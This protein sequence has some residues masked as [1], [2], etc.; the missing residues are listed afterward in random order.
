MQ[1]GKTTMKQLEIKMHIKERR[2]VNVM[3]FLTKIPCQLSMIN[4]SEIYSRKFFVIAMQLKISVSYF[5]LF[6]I[7]ISLIQL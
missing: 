4:I 3:N 2:G 5:L 7:S 1:L 6:T